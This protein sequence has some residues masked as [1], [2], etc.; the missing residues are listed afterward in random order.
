[1]SIM[2]FNTDHIDKKLD[3]L[4]L[5]DSGSNATASPTT[6]SSQINA[7]GAAYQE[8]QYIPPKPQRFNSPKKSL[9]SSSLAGERSTANLVNSTMSINFNTTSTANSNNL[10]AGIHH[11]GSST[12]RTAYFSFDESSNDLNLNNNPNSIEIPNGRYTDDHPEPELLASSVGN[13]MDGHIIPSSSAISLLSLNSHAHTTHTLQSDL[14]PEKA[15]SPKI[16]QQAQQG[17]FAD[18][19]NSFTNIKSRNSLTHLTQQRLQPYQRFTS[20]PP[21]LQQQTQQQQPLTQNGFPNDFYTSHSTSQSIPINNPIIGTEPDSPNLDPTSIGGSPSRFWLS[22][23]TPPHSLANS[24]NRNSRTHLYQMQYQQQI[25]HSSQSQQQ[26]HLMY[27]VAPPQQQHLPPNQPMYIP[28]SNINNYTTSIPKP[29]HQGDHS[30]VLNPVQTP[31]EE[32]PMTPLFLN[33]L[34]GG[35]GFTGDS[36]F[37]DFTVN[38]EGRAVSI[39]DEKENEEEEEEDD[40]TIMYEKNEDYEMNN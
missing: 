15:V 39:I 24:Y 17:A 3:G 37:G 4:K 22:S 38:K 25:P 20:P 26:P 14:H 35:P 23:Q 5:V 11:D 19:K 2:S 1:M 31:S 32:M 10:I 7:S 40:G 33:K 8:N 27:S 21:A 29:N 16:P 9:L 36:Y 34:P 6:S 13:E 28:L 18:R 30:P 12:E